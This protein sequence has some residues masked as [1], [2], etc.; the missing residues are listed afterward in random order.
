MMVLL[1]LVNYS[2]GIYYLHAICGESTTLRFF[3]CSINY[4]YVQ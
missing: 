3:R 4:D 1:G 2:D